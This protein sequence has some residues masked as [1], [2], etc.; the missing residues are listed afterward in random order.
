MGKIDRAVD[1]I[2]RMDHIASRDQWVNSL[3]PLVKFVVAISYIWTVVSFSKYDILGLS[4]MAVYLFVGFT[5]SDL[6]F[7]ACLRRLKIVL[8]LVCIVGIANPFL[9]KTPVLLG[10]LTVRAGV[11]SMVTLMM[12]GVFAVLASYLLVATT[13]IE[14]ICCALRLLHVPGIMVT[15]I[16]LTYRYITLLLD[17]V[18]RTT[19]AYALR[20]PGQKGIH[21]KAWGSL[22][23]QLLL[24]SI[25]RAKEVYE[26]MVLRGYQ[27]EFQYMRERMRL[28]LADA[29]YLIVW[30]AIFA[31]LRTVPVA[32]LIGGLFV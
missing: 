4:T 10:T 11:I 28:R 24:R 19:Q 16:L 1:E 9:D 31:A 13:T 25:D 30:I 22:V 7:A 23:G 3:H 12:K 8:P 5:I 15:Q 21:F 17:E 26:A 20:A 2:H 32:Y 6:S 14:K 18:S 29:V 27:G